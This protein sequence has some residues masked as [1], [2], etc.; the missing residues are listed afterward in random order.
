MELLGRLGVAVRTHARIA[1]A[2]REG[3]RLQDGQLVRGG[4]FVWAGGAKAPELVARFGL[5]TGHNGRVKVDQHLRAL[6]HPEVYAA[7]DVASVVDPRS[8]RTLPPLAQVALEQAETV[9]RNLHAE[10]DGGPLEAFR[11]NDKGFIVSVGSR[12]AS[13]PPARPDL[14][15]VAA[16]RLGPRCRHAPGR[17]RRRGS[18]RTGGVAVALV[19]RQ[20]GHRPATG[21][22]P[23]AQEAGLAE[24]GRCA[25]QGQ[26]PGRPLVE[27]LQ[28]P[29][30][31]QEPGAGAGDM[32][33]GGQ[34]GVSLACGGR[35]R[36]GERLG[37]AEV[38]R[39]CP[40]DDGQL[41][42]AGSIVMPGRSD[43]PGG[44]P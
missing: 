6:D 20:P 8:G 19:Q 24:P 44:G 5:P 12:R 26:L 3:L 33:L 39:W 23:L 4:V 11:F 36:R 31:G 13:P 28:Q 25:D 32:Q 2:T 22:D 34:Q 21:A 17:A 41:P 9:A 37:H 40:P 14:G 43:R 10:L 35:R 15:H 38:A 18:A 27:A 30:P 29:R 42:S 16:P 1:E 7:G